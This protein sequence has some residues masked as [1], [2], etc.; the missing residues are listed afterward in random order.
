MS[1]GQFLSRNC[2][3]VRGEGQYIDYIVATLDTGGSPYPRNICNRGYEFNYT[4]EF[5]YPRSEVI[6]KPGCTWMSA[7][8]SWSE[9]LD[10]NRNAKDG[11]QVCTRTRS[12]H[13][14]GEWSPYACVTI[15][16]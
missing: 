8:V 6:E 9:K 7:G 10:V 12:S 2:I 16:K 3:S 13:S 1:N 5:G 15:E 11:S 14:N 4:D